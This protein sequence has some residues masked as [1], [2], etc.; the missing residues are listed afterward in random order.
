M[1]DGLGRTIEYLRISV[2]DRCNLRCKYCMPQGGI[3]AIA[4]EECLTL[5]EIYH[6]VSI[7]S[8]MGICKVRFTGGEPMV[9]KNLVKL[10]QDVSALP[11]IKEIAMTTNGILLADRLDDYVAAGVNSVNI[12]LDTL[13]EAAFAQITGSNDHAKV[14]AA[15]KA[16]IDKGIKLKINCVPG[17]EFNENSYLEVAKLAKDYPVDVRFIELMPIGCG[18]DFTRITG[19][20]TL[21]KLAE[22]YGTY[23]REEA[24][25]QCGPAQYVR[26]KGFAGRIGFID[27][28]SHKF[29]ASCNRI[30]LTV[31]GKLKLCLYYSEHLDLRKLLREGATDQQIEIAILEAL[32]RKPKEH[33]FG[34]NKDQDA[35]KMVQIGG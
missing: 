32:Q 20:E 6:I 35:R 8:K 34:E 17:K 9:R 21:Q 33:F 28:M 3:E 19:E 18:K 14:M 13:D 11:E 4:H 23:T 5:E 25:K 2:T 7:L 16:C 27:P 12:S 30:R 15:I 24:G 22:Q 10:I 31:D 29:C 1:I 26:F